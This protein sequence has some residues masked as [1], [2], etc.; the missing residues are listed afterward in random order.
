MSMLLTGALALAGLSGCERRS[1]PSY[2]H[3]EEI[4]ASGWDP[5]DVLT[6]EPVPYDSTES[7]RTNYAVTLVIRYTSRHKI[8]PLPIAVTIE[9]C[10]GPIKTDTITVDT[11]SRDSLTQR[12]T[13]YGITEL[14]LPLCSNV[15][16]TEGCNIRLESFREKTSTLGL[17][18]VGLVMEPAPSKN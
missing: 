5:L 11:E 2:S 1:T 16:I 3:F 7:R 14:H 8:P 15:A 18:N 9:D 12:A 4:P 10:N 13:R 17:L 6:F